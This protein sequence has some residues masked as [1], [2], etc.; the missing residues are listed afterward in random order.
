MRHSRYTQISAIFEL[1][2][3]AGT[4]SPIV[5]SIRKIAMKASACGNIC[6]TSSVVRLARRPLKR[7]R[8]NAYAP[9]AP[10]STD[11]TAVTPPISSVLPNHTQ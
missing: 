2:P 1:M 10:M 3:R 4:T 6:S 11:P 7:N 8:E 9:Q 5:C